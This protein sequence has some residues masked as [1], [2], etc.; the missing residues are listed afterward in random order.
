MWTL[1]KRTAVESWSWSPRNGATVCSPAS[2]PHT[3]PRMPAAAAEL[4]PEYSNKFDQH[5]YNTDN[6]NIMNCER[7]CF[8]LFWHTILRAQNGTEK[9]NKNDSHMFFS[10]WNTMQCTL[11]QNKLT[12]C[13]IIHYYCLFPL[14]TKSWPCSVLIR[15]ISYA[16][17]THCPFQQELLLHPFWQSYKLHRITDLTCCN[18]WL[19]SLIKQYYYIGQSAVVLTSHFWPFY[20]LWKASQASREGLWLENWKN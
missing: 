7:F 2:H 8:C 13:G 3:A 16:I 12:R 14:T 6:D 20:W 5:W 1:Q 15:K 17:A 19:W 18:R 10:C 4:C 9:L 11:T